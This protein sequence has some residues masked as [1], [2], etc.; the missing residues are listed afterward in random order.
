MH[1][2]KVTGNVS[3]KLRSFRGL[4]YCNLS[5][6]LD[7]LT[8]RHKYVIY[9]IFISVILELGFILGLLITDM[10]S[11]PFHSRFLEI[12]AMQIWIPQSIIDRYVVELIFF[13]FC[14]SS[15]PYP[16]AT[17]LFLSQVL[18]TTYS[19]VFQNCVF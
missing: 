19:F 6:A 13:C 5:A 17:C 16:Q 15:S 2:P 8:F 18:V 7:F 11:G 10:T 3:F 12:F 4:S 9:N 14:S 1:P